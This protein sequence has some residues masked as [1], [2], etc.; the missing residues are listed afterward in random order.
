MPGDKPTLLI[1]TLGPEADSCRRPLVPGRL[2]PAEVALR[3]RCLEA[4]LEAGGAAG[5]RVKVSSPQPLAL[6]DGVEPLPQRGATFA[7]RLRR[8]I[9]DARAGEGPL[10]I[11]GADVPGLRTD[12]LR[13]ALDHLR[14]DPGAVVVGPSPDGGFYLLASAR[15]LDDELRAVHWCGPDAL[16]SL[17]AAL[18]A[19]DHRAILLESLGDLDRPADLEGWLARR[20][21]AGAAWRELRR[22]LRRLLEALRRPPAPVSIPKPL[23]AFVPVRPGRAPPRAGRRPWPAP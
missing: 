6:P 18:R 21:A 9:R 11:I 1:F 2:R 7:E 10:L 22:L 19:R 17:L 4:A 16:S 23:P 15:P 20:A 5:C 8:A 12:H 14:R 3:R 13:A